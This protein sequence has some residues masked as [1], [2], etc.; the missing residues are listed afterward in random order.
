MSDSDLEAM[1]R[2]LAEKFGHMDRRQR[3]NELTQDEVREAVDMVRARSGLSVPSL[4][5]KLK[6]R[7]VPIRL[8]LLVLGETKPTQALDA[9]KRIVAGEGILCAISGRTGCGKSAAAAWALSR[10]PGLW[11]HAPVL[12]RVQESKDGERDPIDARMASCGLLVIDDVG[13]EHSPS[14]FAPSRITDAVISREAALL[15]T[16][17]TTNL[18]GQEFKARYGDR[19]ASRL[20][21]D[22]IGFVTLTDPDLRPSQPDPRAAAA[23]GDDAA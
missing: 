9:A 12:A 8:A 18:S 4:A 17:L 20:N 21:G 3:R 6:Q 16:L 7:G 1:V 23:G 11:V 2:G 15:P 22:P 14:E 19:L 5:D 13:A 10:R